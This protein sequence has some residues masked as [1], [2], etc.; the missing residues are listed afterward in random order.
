MIEMKCDFV[1]RC[2]KKSC[3]V[4][5][6]IHGRS[7]VKKWANDPK[8]PLKMRFLGFL[9]QNTHFYILGGDDSEPWLNRLCHTRRKKSCNWNFGNKPIYWVWTLKIKDFEKNQTQ[10][11]KLLLKTLLTWNWLF[12][13]LK[14]DFFWNTPSPLSLSSSLPLVDV[15]RR[16]FA[17]FVMNY[18]KKSDHISFHRFSTRNW[19]AELLTRSVWGSVSGPVPMYAQTHTHTHP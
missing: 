18:E 10:S 5:S 9:S 7:H 4:W 3:I 11:S 13:S 12:D 6:Q 2:R 19:V 14:N 15:K 8:N 16:K 1:Q 17:G